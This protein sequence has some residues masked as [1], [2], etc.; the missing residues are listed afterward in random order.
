MIKKVLYLVICCF[1][2]ITLTN[3]LSA[4]E[5]LPDEQPDLETATFHLE[6]GEIMIDDY[7]LPPLVTSPSIS[8]ASCTGDYNT[9][10]YQDKIHFQDLEGIHGSKGLETLAAYM[11]QNFNH[12]IG[13]A[14]TYTGVIATGYGDCWGLSD[15]ALNV[16]VKNGYKVR[17]IQGITSQ[18][19]NHRWLEVQLEDGSWTTF[20]PSMV[21]K[22]YNY[23]PYNYQCGHPTMTLEVYG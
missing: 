3:P 2:T 1:L 5:D 8:L 4:T 23:K 11:Q 9:K 10:I 16:L 20:D 18:A 21:T 15:F 19:N 22:K 6:T 17:L 7:T 13:A 14:T 12:N